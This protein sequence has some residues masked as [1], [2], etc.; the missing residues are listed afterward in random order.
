MFFWEVYEFFR[1]SHRT[2]FMKKAVLN[3]F[4][5]L[6]EICRPTT[7]FKRDS[8]SSHTEVFYEKGVLKICSKFTGEQ[9]CRSV[10]SIKLLCNFIEITHLH[11]CSP[12]NL[13]HIFRTPFPRNTSGRLLLRLQRR[14]P[15]NIAKFL[16]TPVLKNIC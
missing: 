1:S 10:V 13:L 2:C 3:N 8:R 14:C 11:C 6:Q 12:V 9:P 7:Y 4:E 15:L 5:I 16:R